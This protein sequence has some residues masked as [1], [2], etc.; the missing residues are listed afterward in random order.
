LAGLAL[1]SGRAVVMPEVAGDERWLVLEKHMANGSA[2]ALPLSADR[3]ALGVITLA[4]SLAG[5][6]ST[7]DLP[8]FEHVAFCASLAL[9]AAQSRAEEQSQRNQT[10]SLFA[11]SQ[12]AASERSLDGLADDLLDKSCELF[13]ATQVGLFLPDDNKLTL[14]GARAQPDAGAAQSM[15]AIL[16]TL[17]LVAERAWRDQAPVTEAVAEVVRGDA[18]SLPEIEGAANML[19]VALPL[20][21]NGTAVGV[22]ALARCAQG[23]AVFSA[24]VWSMLTILTNV[25]AAAFANRQMIGQLHRRTE[26]LEELVRERTSQLQN[27]RDLLRVLFDHLPDGLVLL[28]NNGQILA[29]NEAFCR[30]VVGLPLSE[31]IGRH[32]AALTNQ[33]EQRSLLAFGPRTD[34]PTY[35][36]RR[37]GPAGR[38][39]WYEVDRYSVVSGGAQVIERWRD[40][41]SQEELRHQL[42]LHEQLASLGRLAASVVHE[43]GNPLQSV[44]SCLE[45]CRETSEL[46]ESA[47]EYL[48]LAGGELRRMSHILAQLRDLYRPQRQEWKQVDLNDLIHT[49]ER[50]TAPQLRRDRVAVELALAPG[51]PIVK[52]QAGALH[53]VLLNLVL[54]AVSAMPNGGVI[55]I[56]TAFDASSQLCAISIADTG[57][58]MN[59][60]QL[61]QIFEPFV[62][63]TSQGLGLGLYLSHQIVQQHRGTIDIT[64]TVNL[65]TTVTVFLPTSEANDEK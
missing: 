19:C 11:M 34:E 53:Q 55:N 43:V 32:Y 12:S 16:D 58:G 50:I 4:H 49:V 56:S 38:Q 30:E 37:T 60:R 61:S 42:L 65:G 25:A 39:S 46:P 33:L 40:M 26:L 24:R 63:G 8:L 52:G 45:L 18:A 27:S 23:M 2:I 57:V 3:T 13:N 22:F 48:E 21:H 1:R 14:V 47:L 29:A 7:H 36:A 44:R 17:A 59:P 31:V 20:L 9:S 28:D 54:N 6:L 5:Q 15:P 35:G 10:L 62:T 51:L 64:S 41:T